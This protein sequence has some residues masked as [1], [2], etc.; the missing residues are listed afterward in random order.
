MNNLLF[1]IL[2][3]SASLAATASTP[4]RLMEVEDGD[5]L[6]VD[7][8]GAPTRIQLLGI[9]APEDRPNPKFNLDRERSGLPAEQLLELGRQATAYL[10]TQVKSGE[11]L[12]LHGNLNKKDRYGRIN[13]EVINAAGQNLNTEMVKS[14]LARPLHPETLPEDLRQRLLHAWSLGKGKMPESF[15][16]WLQ[17]QK[18]GTD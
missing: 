18:E 16:A 7:L 9:D 17:V 13:A 3:I 4:A 8:D 6:L 14:G 15:A 11:A 12:Q 2:L 5:T 1:S 10:S